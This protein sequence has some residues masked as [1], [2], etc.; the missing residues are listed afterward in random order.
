MMATDNQSPMYSKPTDKQRGKIQLARKRMRD[1][2]EGEKDIMSKIST[3]M[4]KAARDEQKMAKRD[5]ESIPESARRYEG[6]EGQ[7]YSPYKK[8]GKVMNESMMMKKEGRGMAKADMQKVA[9]K[10]VKGHEKRMHGMKSG[11]SVSKR[12]DGC[13]MR[14]KTRGKMV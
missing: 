3:T 13:A 2:M 10:A 5:M 7:D 4:A 12:A 8:G 9:S 6:E 11:G 14:G 1:A